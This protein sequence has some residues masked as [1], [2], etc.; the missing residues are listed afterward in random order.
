ML[1]HWLWYAERKMSAHHKR[2]LLE[3]FHDAEEIFMATRERLEQID[4]MSEELCEI[5]LDKNLAAACYLKGQCR[6]YHISVLT[7]T[8]E[9]YPE[10]LR[11]LYDAPVVLYYQGVL[12][13]WNA[14]P[15]IG[16]VGTR[17]AT[18]YGCGIA[19]D[20][21]SQIAACG[22]MVVS[23]GAKG[24]DTVAL[25]SAYR[26]GGAV[27]AV[28]AGGLDKLYPASNISLFH[29][30]CNNGCLITEY[31]P[32]TPSVSR[33]F[34]IRN[35]I[36]SGI[37]NGLLVV[38]A[39]LKSG[40]L[41]TARH[42]MEQGRDVFSVPGNLDMPTCAGTNALLR[43]GARAVMT[44]YDV[45][46]EYAAQY[47]NKICRRDV[48]SVAERNRQ[49]VAQIP[50]VVDTSA[51]KPID[52][53]EKSTYSVVHTVNSALTEQER[54]LVACV[55]NGGSLTDDVIARSGMNAAEA[56]KLLTMLA[57]KKVLVL[58]PGGRVTLN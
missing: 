53:L 45:I 54:K 57:L 56:K 9:R 4:G 15:M 1:E 11:G 37:A 17:Q 52:N 6:A 27:V 41:I 33:N 7:F 35:R 20:M 19:A 40:A 3:H 23:G 26:A 39:P 47:P 2:M 51:K 49:N 8:D 12:P 21:S 32:G 48:P 36:I 13:D 38:E 30:I 10:R 34:P 31:P 18:T 43:E 28:L 5:L 44:G 46:G 29:R 22:G 24:I 50:A 16:I 42:A 58:H 55:G 25:E 14:L